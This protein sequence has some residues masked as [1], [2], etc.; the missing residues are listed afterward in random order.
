MKNM[1]RLV[2]IFL[3]SAFI[4]AGCTTAENKE[5]ITEDSV[6]MADS[7]DGITKNDS[8]EEM[9][10]YMDISP[11]DAKKLIDSN[12]NLIIIDVSP[13]Y[14]DGHLPNAV[15]YYVGDGSLDT[16]ILMLDKNADYLV[17]CH[18]DSASILGAQKLIDAG[19]KKVYRLE[20]NYSA[21]LDAGF[22]IEK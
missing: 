20:G 15:N 17:Y 2:M 14:K 8:S 12:E 16:A 21:W 19:F 3:L 13:F 5:M 22:D 7:A 6:P 18:S 1:T 4:L 9:I 10:S 11:V